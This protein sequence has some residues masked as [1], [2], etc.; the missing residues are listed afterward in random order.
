VVCLSSNREAT[1]E[2]LHRLAVF[3]SFQQRDNPERF[4]RLAVCLF[5]NSE[6][7]RERFHLLV[8][9]LSLPT[10]EQPANSV[11]F[12]QCDLTPSSGFIAIYEIWF[13]IV[14]SG[15]DHSQYLDGGF[16]YEYSL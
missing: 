1:R 13:H 10:A 5:S 2:R 4:H 11:F 9:Y 7:T 6:A 15:F 3:F 8:I 16:L 14:F 12:V